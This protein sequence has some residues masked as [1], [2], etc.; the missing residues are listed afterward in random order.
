ME[1]RNPE[2]VLSVKH[3]TPLVTVIEADLWNGQLPPYSMLQLW[4]QHK[5]DWATDKAGRSYPTRKSY[6]KSLVTLS[7][8]Q[9]KKS[10]SYQECHLCPPIPHLSVTHNTY[11]KWDPCIQ[12]TDGELSVLN[13]SQVVLQQHL[14][15]WF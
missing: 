10:R 5:C 1:L 4:S 12:C 14:E 9:Y 3:E 8:T 6:F 15:M 13:G 7:P 11:L 2:D